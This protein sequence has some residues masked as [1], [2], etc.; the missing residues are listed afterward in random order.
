MEGPSWYAILLP[1]GDILGSKIPFNASTSGRKPPGV[2][3]TRR[4]P[5]KNSFFGRTN[6]QMGP[7]DVVAWAAFLTS[8]VGLPPVRGT[9]H[10]SHFV[11]P[12]GPRG[13]WKITFRPSGL[14]VAAMYHQPDSGDPS[15]RSMR[16]LRPLTMSSTTR[17]PK[18]PASPDPSRRWYTIFVLSGDHPPA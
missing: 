1:S 4:V 8:S 16:V 6:A 12:S 15:P 11:M 14:K 3:I 10:R 18:G 5:S 9:D 2:A 13:S 17:S 7:S